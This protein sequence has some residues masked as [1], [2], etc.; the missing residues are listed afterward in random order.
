GSTTSADLPATTTCSYTGCATLNGA[1]NAYIA[2]ITPPLGSVAAILDDLTYLGGSGVEKPVGVKVDGGQNP[3]IAGTKSS[4]DFPTVATTA[5]Q[6]TVYSGSK[7]TTHVFVSRLTN[8]F[9]TLI[10]SSYLSG[11]GTDTA[12]GMAIDAAGEIFVTGSTSSNNLGSSSI[13]FPASASP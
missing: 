5:Y 12:S 8:D 11:N 9:S 1:Q 13:Q 2:K 10:Y 6:S 3:Y 7:G 4:T